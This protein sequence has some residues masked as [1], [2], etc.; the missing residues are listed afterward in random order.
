MQL[1]MEE[2]KD[3]T[4][5][6]VQST[7]SPKAVLSSGAHKGRQTL[8]TKRGAGWHFKHLSVEGSL[9]EQALSHLLEH[10]ALSVCLLLPLL[11]V[12]EIQSNIPP[13]SQAPKYCM[14]KKATDIWLQSQAGTGTRGKE[15][16]GNPLF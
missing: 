7:H 5:T 1:G 4:E 6:K 9:K 12:T 10:N 3:G 16:S 14:L 15:Q 8:L 13:H 11:F 2:D